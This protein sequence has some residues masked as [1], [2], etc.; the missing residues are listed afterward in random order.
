MGWAWNFE[1]I[2]D[3]RHGKASLLAIQECVPFMSW[4]EN[5]KRYKQGLLDKTLI[6]CGIT[7]TRTT[8]VLVAPS[9]W[10]LLRSNTHLNG[11]GIA[12]S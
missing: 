1:I 2:E 7:K 9:S 10:P 6:G 11:H 12:L 5:K 4:A 8:G 3:F